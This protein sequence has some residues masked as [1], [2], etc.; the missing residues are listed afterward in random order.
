MID[1]EDWGLVSSKSGDKLK[2]EVGFACEGDARCEVCGLASFDGRFPV[3]DECGGCEEC[4]HDD[5]CSE[6]LKNMPTNLK[7]AIQRIKELQGMCKW[8]SEEFLRLCGCGEMGC[9]MCDYGFKM[10]AA[11]RGERP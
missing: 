9:V 6:N 11:S 8:A 3:C 10:G 7:D 4:G 2:R 1:A 5:E